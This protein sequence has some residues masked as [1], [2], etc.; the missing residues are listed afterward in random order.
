MTIYNIMRIRLEPD[1][2]NRYKIILP[3]KNND[4]PIGLVY[5]DILKNTNWRL[6]AY[7]MTSFKEDHIIERVYDDS[8]TAARALA[9]IYKKIEIIS[10][11][12][13]TD[14]F[15]VVWPDDTASD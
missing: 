12:E 1:G 14:P 10:L 11:Q 4:F 3:G 7:F 6:K 13:K 15:H 9:R 8:M 5:K 2:L